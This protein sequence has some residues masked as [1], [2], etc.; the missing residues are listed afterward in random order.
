MVRWI[1]GIVLAS[2]AVVTAGVVA[3]VLLTGGA[4]PPPT[5]LPA[6]QSSV[7]QA[8][9]PPPKIPQE[10]SNLT[11]ML[12]G[13]AQDAEDG[14]VDAEEVAAR[15]PV[16][17]E[18]TVAVTV[19]ARDSVDEVERFLNDADVAVRNRGR[20]YLE[21]F[22]PV[23]LLG[24]LSEL[25]GVIRVEPVVEPSVNQAVGSGVGGEGAALHGPRLGTLWGTTG[26]G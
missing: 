17:Y 1:V 23:G 24:A 20:T 22:V 21:A 11:S 13:L 7:D 16:S 9:E 12:D 18:G 4:S 3:L 19:Y 14:S 25:D 15:A 5:P 10:Y 26:A 2:V 6:V 8:P